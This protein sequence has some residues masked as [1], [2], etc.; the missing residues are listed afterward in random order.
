[1]GLLQIKQLQI[2]MRL[3]IDAL[4]LAKRPDLFMKIDAGLAHRIARLQPHRVQLLTVEPQL[5]LELA[6]VVF[7]VLNVVF[8]THASHYTFFPT[9]GGS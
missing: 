3:A 9:D 6:A 5:P 2:V 8:G 1:M 7:S 4:L